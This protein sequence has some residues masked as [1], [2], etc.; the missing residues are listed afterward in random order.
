MAGEQWDRCVTGGG[1]GG[2]RRTAGPAV[3]LCVISSR[4]PATCPF[5]SGFPDLYEGS[6]GSHS[7]LEQMPCPYA[8]ASSHAHLT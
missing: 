3:P 7:S 4:V 6:A 2:R 1:G 8:A 5:T